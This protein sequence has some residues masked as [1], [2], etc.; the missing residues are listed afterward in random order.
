[1]ARERLRHSHV[2]GEPAL[3]NPHHVAGHGVESD[4]PA[5]ALG[6]VHQPVGHDRRRQPAP[7]VAHRV[8]PH[9]PQTRD[10]GAVDLSERTECRHVVGPA[11]VH[12]VTGLRGLQSRRRDRR[13]RRRRRGRL[14]GRQRAG[15]Q[16]DRERSHHSPAASHPA[17]LAPSGASVS[18]RAFL[19][20]RNGMAGTA[21]AL[22]RRKGYRN[23]VAA[24]RSVDGYLQ[25]PGRSVGLRGTT[26]TSG[27]ATG[28]SRRP[29]QARRRRW[30]SLEEGRWQSR[31]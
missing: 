3:V 14:C 10:A 1:M 8:R 30:R 13:G 9:R 20:Y 21:S 18:R 25:T 27:R 26:T 6:H 16:A 12:P 5:A 22:G 29:R 7:V 17:L 19:R 31:V 28:G 11:I 4:D 24:A 15:Q 2:L 23:R